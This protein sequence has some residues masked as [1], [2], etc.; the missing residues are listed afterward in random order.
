MF[1]ALY[2]CASWTTFAA[3][4]KRPTE[5]VYPKSTMFYFVVRHLRWLARIPGLPQL[6]DALMLAATWLFCRDRLAAMEDL[7]LQALRLPGLRL[8]VHK[9]GGTEFVRDGRE[10]G[11]LHGNGL[12]D[13]A[14]GRLT[15]QT[16]LAAGRVQPH[17]VFPNSKWVSF[18]LES[19]RDVA[20]GVELLT[21]ANA[22]FPMG[23]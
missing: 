17:H 12:L 22:S 16:L 10:L 5:L 6:F 14:L 21:T 11:H 13:V 4:R 9:L 23:R 19:Q 2:I 3:E 20:F 7:E 1:S 18:Q 8:K 15:A